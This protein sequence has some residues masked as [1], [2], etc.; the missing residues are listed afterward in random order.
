M[1]EPI[2]ES[3][4]P[5]GLA[6]TP[7]DPTFRE[8]PYPVLAELREREPIHHDVEFGRWIFTRHDDVFAILRDPKYWSDPRKANPDSFTRRFLGNG[9]EEPSMLLM[10][11]PNHRRL[12]ELVRHPF[13]P[14]AIER[15]REPARAVARRTV[16]A[17]DGDEFDLIG[18][19]ANPIPTVVIAELLGIDPELHGQFKGWSDDVIVTA[20][21]PVNAPEDVAKAEK[22]REKLH[23]FFM[24]EIEARRRA[25]SDD[26]IS[27][28]V[29]AEESGDRL[30]D[31][32][33]S[34]QCNLL[35]LAG[36]LTTSDFI[37]N[38]V[39]ALIRNPDE[40]AKLRADRSLMKNAVEETLRYDSPV[41]NSGRIAYDDLEFDGIK[42]PKG[43]GLM[44]STASANRDPSA[45]PEPDRYDITR[46]DTHHQAF[47]GGRH[48]CLGAHLARMEAAE[49]IEALL[50]TF[51]NLEFGSGDYEYASNSAFRGLSRFSVKGARRN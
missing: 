45:Y 23:A 2:T 18:Q 15:W 29:R 46:K 49:T 39:M 6:L 7:L 38:F 37:G 48:F 17:I 30:T 24:A 28:M 21:S 34:L 19:V 5:T 13:S 27:A 42:I 40:Q 44:V 25:P 16:A 47:G 10:D 33:I 1:A 36:N 31:E 35:L 8:D 43:E 26:L 3:P 4:V 12:R 20:F 50:D 51:E 41:T 9:D 11:D 14:R 32:E 22:A